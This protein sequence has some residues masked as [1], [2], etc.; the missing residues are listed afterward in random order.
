MTTVGGSIESI[1]IKGRN[2]AVASDAD[3][4]RKLGGFENEVQSNGNGTARIVKTRV[5]WSLSGVTVEVDDARG[6]QEFLQEIADAK[7]FVDIL[8]TLASG[9]SYQGRGTLVEALEGST[10]NATAELSMMGPG[11]ATKQ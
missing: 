8:I 2:F 6:D 10:Q 11:Q 7:D 1:T 5:P 9:V 4:Q 3:A